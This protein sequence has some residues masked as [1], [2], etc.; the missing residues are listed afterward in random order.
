MRIDYISD[1]H[2]DHY[3]SDT[4][5]SSPKFIKKMEEL[6]RN[7]IMPAGIGTDFILGEVLIVAGDISHYNQ[8]SMFFLIELKKYYDNIILVHGNHDMYLISSKQASKYQYSSDLRINELKDICERLN[9]IFLDGDIVNFKNIRIGGT[10]SWYNLPTSIDIENWKK[11]MNDSEYIYST[12]PKTYYYV[13]TS[14]EY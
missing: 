9:V 10:C 11:V 13:E 8:Q 5:A 6:V 7:R 14:K 4:N 12:K 2:L 3:I 1:V